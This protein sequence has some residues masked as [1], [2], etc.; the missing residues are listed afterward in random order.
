VGKKKPKSH[1][2]RPMPIAPKV[3]AEP[4]SGTGAGTG[5]GTGS[6][7]KARTSWWFDFEIDRNHLALLRFAFFAVLAVDAFLQLGHA[8]RYGAGGFNVGHVPWLPLPAPSRERMVIVDLVLTYLFAMTAVG[9]GTRITVPAAAVLFNYGYFVSQLD[10]YQHH[11]LVAMLLI[12]AAFV[13]WHARQERV[14]SWA[15][16]LFTVQLALL[17]LWAALAKLE[18]RWLDGAA[19][20]LQLRPE[21]VRDLVGSNWALLAKAI[22]AG[23]L[24]LAALWLWRRGW[25]AALPIGLGFHISVELADFKI[26]Q[27][28]YL[29]IAIYTLCLPTV[30]GAWPARALGRLTERL[31]R[32]TVV[33]GGVALAAAIGLGIA[34]LLLA[35]LGG[36]AWVI[37]LTAAVALGAFALARTWTV[38]A[39][40]VAACA[41]VLLLGHTTEQAVD[42]YRLWAGSANRLGNMAEVREA[43]AALVALDPD[44]GSGNYYLGNLAYSDG[45]LDQALAHFLAGQRGNP[46]S[47]RLY[48]GE[49]KVLLANG[50][51][52]GAEVAIER[53]LA[54]DPQHREAL[55]VQAQIAGATP[56]APP[57]PG[58]DPGDDHDHD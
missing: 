43:S 56:A 8:P 9:V 50:D 6:S 13:P 51:K 33:A 16:R 26:G 53:A 48:V 31:P 15:L 22:V 14:K 28:S 10:S 54:L 32:G 49:A 41:L 44:N 55:S 36:G 7:A 12:I 27:F 3:S 17:Y 40:H 58:E 5:T 46:K 47:P 19:L 30:V 35:P 23:E 34:L 39:A 1:K 42:Y 45:K 2:P 4:R 20:K 11:Y 21:W 38:A 57:Q 37:V 29:M 25:L 52:I 18:P 24:A